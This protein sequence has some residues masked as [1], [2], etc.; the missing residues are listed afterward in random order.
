VVDGDLAVG[1]AAADAG[2]DTRQELRVQ[3]IG[4]GDVEGA[5]RFLGHEGRLLDEQALGLV[6]DALGGLEQALAVLGRHHAARAAHQQRIA[7]QLAQFAQRG[8]DRRLRLVQ[9]EGHARHVLLHQQQVEDAD[10]VQVEVL[11]QAAHEKVIKFVYPCAYVE[12]TVFFMLNK[13][14]PVYLVCVA[15]NSIQS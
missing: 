2:N 7:G 5:R 8:R 14:K 11:G 13:W 1:R 6:E 15:R 4:R 3:V 12:Y 9:L 10:Q